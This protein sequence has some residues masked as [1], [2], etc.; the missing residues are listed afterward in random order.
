MTHKSQQPD[1][2]DASIYSD[3]C[4]HLRGSFRLPGPETGDQA[5]PMVTARPKIAARP[6]IGDS[7]LGDQPTL[8]HYPT[9]VE[10]AGMVLGLGDDED[11]IVYLSDAHGISRYSEVRGSARGLRPGACVYACLV[12]QL[13]LEDSRLVPVQTSISVQTSP[14]LDLSRGLPRDPS[15][16][17][18]VVL[19]SPETVGIPAWCLMRTEG[20]EAQFAQMLIKPERLLPLRNPSLV[21]HDFVGLKGNAGVELASLAATAEEVIRSSPLRFCRPGETPGAG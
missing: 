9:L 2:N 11:A 12:G 17:W 3:R 10:I 5:M 1:V 7:S 14:T 20:F 15:Q 6:K 16:P 19:I 13:G 18:G 8:C 21:G 4:R